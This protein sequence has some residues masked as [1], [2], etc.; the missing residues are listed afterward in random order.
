M[1]KWHAA[2]SKVCLLLDHSPLSVEVS[3]TAHIVT[4]LRRNMD[5]QEL[6]EE[7]YQ[8]SWICRGNVYRNKRKSSSFVIM[9]RIRGGRFET[10][11]SKDII[12]VKPWIKSKWRAVVITLMNFGF[13]KMWVI[14]GLSEELLASEERLCSSGKLCTI[15]NLLNCVQYCADKNPPPG[16]SQINP[17][18]NVPSCFWRSIV[19]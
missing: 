19:M 4:C 5:R 1:L 10:R 3:C 18:H 2:F 13:H 17:V 8:V 16:P 12:N 7:P 14:S 9:T 6:A 11:W 15:K